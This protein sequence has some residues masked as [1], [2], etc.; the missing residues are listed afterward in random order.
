MK[1]NELYDLNAVAVAARRFVTLAYT[2]DCNDRE[3]IA[4]E[5]ALSIA[6][7]HAGYGPET[8]PEND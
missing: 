8:E 7:S 6:L 2:H 3:F 4:A 5:L 1:T